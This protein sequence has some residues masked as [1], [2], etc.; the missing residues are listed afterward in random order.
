MTRIQYV[1][2]G[3]PI[4][5]DF[6][7]LV[8]ATGAGTAKTA[9]GFGF[10]ALAPSRKLLMPAHVLHTGSEIV[11][12]SATM[13]GQPASLVASAVGDR[14]GVLT[15]VL[16]IGGEPPGTSGDVVLTFS[17]AGVGCTL[18]GYRALNMRS[19][20]PHAKGELGFDTSSPDV[21]STSADTPEG[22]LFLATATVYHDG[23][24][25][26]LS[27]VTPDYPTTPAPSLHIFGGFEVITT[28][29]PGKSAAITKSGGAGSMGG[30]L[31]VAS[32]R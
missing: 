27:G 26:L 14:S 13:G 7:G 5:V 3:G 32:F 8:S 20:T 9:A 25:T 23:G 4:E 12:V 21:R 24:S 10:G 1:D 19:L 2:G 6:L 29:E 16:L 22:G 11:L 15:G 30:G 28:A 31:I 18:A 17:E